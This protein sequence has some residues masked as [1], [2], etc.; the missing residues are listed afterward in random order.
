[1]CPTAPTSAQGFDTCPSRVIMDGPCNNLT[2]TLNQWGFQC[3]PDPAG[4]VRYSRTAPPN[5]SFIVDGDCDASLAAVMGYSCRALAAGG[6]QYYKTGCNPDLSY[7]SPTGA[8]W[9]GC[10]PLSSG[11]ATYTRDDPDAWRQLSS[12]TNLPLQTMTTGAP[13]QQ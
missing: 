8:G 11:G 9:T 5:W 4:G 6:S 1:Q 10:T 3:D 13:Q 2:N 12:M 7:S